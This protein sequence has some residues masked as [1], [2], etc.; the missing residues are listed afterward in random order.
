MATAKKG[1]VKRAPAKTTPAK[2]APARKAPAKKAPARKAPARKSASAKQPGTAAKTRA[3]KGK[4]REYIKKNS[5]QDKAKR[6][7]IN[8]DAKIRP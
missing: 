1:P 3:P 4:V 7:M 2:K 6:P 5:L 8:A